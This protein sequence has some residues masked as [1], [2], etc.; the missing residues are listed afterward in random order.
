MIRRMW[1]YIAGHWFDAWSERAELAAAGL[2]RRAARWRKKS[3]KF[4][5]A[6]GRKGAE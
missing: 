5:R 3:E 4:F 2:H 1:S 6:V